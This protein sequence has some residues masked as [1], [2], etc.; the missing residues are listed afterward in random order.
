MRSKYWHI[1]GRLSFS[2]GDEVKSVF[3]GLI[4]STVR[5]DHVLLRNT[6]GKMYFNFGILALCVLHSIFHTQDLKWFLI[7]RA[8]ST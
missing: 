4:Y 6:S 8:V 2:E 1:A 3:C 7:N 5:V